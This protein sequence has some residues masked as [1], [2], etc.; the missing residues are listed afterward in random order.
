MN[1]KDLAIVIPAYKSKFFREALQSL[2][3]QTVKDFTIYVGDDCSPEDLKSV[4]DEF[5]DLDIFYYR[6]EENLGGKDLV[7]QWTRCV[8]LSKNERWIWLFSDDDIVDP[9][10]VEK[11]YETSKESTV[12]VLRFNTA[13]IDGDGRIGSYAPVGPEFES[14]EMMAYYILRGERGNSMPDHIF[15]RSVYDQKKGFVNTAY[16]QSADWATSILFSQD[17]GIRIIPHAIVYWRRSGENISSLAA[18]K[19]ASIQTGYIQFIYWVADHFQY[20]RQ[21]KGNILYAQMLDAIRLNF[22]IVMTGH[23]QG[24]SLKNLQAIVAVMRGPLELS[25][26]KCFAYTMKIYSKTGPIVKFLVKCKRMI[27]KIS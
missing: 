2:A 27:K 12:D 25:W 14:S 20:L 24:F 9:I 19:K 15:S 26:F 17:K 21:N 16:G 8:A 10:C 7:G 11:F 18:K 22:L 4:V 23:Y 5:P 1:E 6:F 3:S 13:V